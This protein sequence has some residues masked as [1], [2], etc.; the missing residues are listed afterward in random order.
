MKN[1]TKALIAGAAG[2]ALLGGGSTFALWNASTGVNGGTITN[3]DLNVQAINTLSWKDVSGD[4]VDKGHAINLTNWKMVPGDTIEGTQDIDVALLGDNLSATLSL[5]KAAGD[6]LP[7]G[8]S[9]AYDVTNAAGTAIK[10]GTDLS[11]VVVYLQSSDNA[12]KDS[13]FTTVGDKLDNA[14]D[15]KV[16]VRVTFDANARD[17]VLD[18][19]TLT[20]LSV[21]LQQ[22]RHAGV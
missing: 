8:V 4:R 16:V 19:S 3:G 14:A 12:K 13:T 9:I 22:F 11:S 20:G 17:K 2:I 10:T 1:K 7:A 6:T 15:L 21:N 5:S 18:T